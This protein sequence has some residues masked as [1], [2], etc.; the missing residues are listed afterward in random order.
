M[1]YMNYKGFV[2]SVCYEDN[3]L[4]GRVQNIYSIISYEGL[5]EEELEMHFVE[6]VDEYI[7]T[8]EEYKVCPYTGKCRENRKILCKK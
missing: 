7:E 2:G 6:A 5:N 8:C 4:Y 3:Y 1:K